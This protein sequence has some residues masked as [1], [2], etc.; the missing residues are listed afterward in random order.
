MRMDTQ[1]LG[2]DCSGATNGDRIALARAPRSSR[3]TLA[4]PA[5]ARRVPSPLAPRATRNSR[6]ALLPPGGTGRE[7]QPSPTTALRELGAGGV[8]G[9]TPL[10]SFFRSW[11]W[12]FPS[13]SHA[14]SSEDRG[15]PGLCVTTQHLHILHPQKSEQGARTLE[16]LLA[17]AEHTVSTSALWA[18]PPKLF[19]L[20]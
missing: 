7:P 18:S 5:K 13:H 12:P 2:A 4:E 8:L 6:G 17:E 15:M 3:G 10:G 11:C 16:I 20:L 9:F 14:V 1:V 19:L